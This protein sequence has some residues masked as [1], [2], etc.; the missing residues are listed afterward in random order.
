MVAVSIDDNENN[1]LLVEAFASSLGV[2]VRS[3]QDPQKALT[4]LEESPRAVDIVFVDYMMPGLNGL[5]VIRRYRAL[6]SNVPMVMITAAG[7]DAKLKLEA[8]EAGATDFL[9]KPLNAAEFK[10]RTANLLSLRK[11]QRLLE[12][13][14]EL[15]ES[16]VLKATRDIVEREHESLLVLG[17]TAEFKD[18]E[19]GSHIARVAHYSKLLARL[20]GLGEGQQD[21]IFYASPFHD[22]GKVGISDA[23][24]LKPG[25]LDEDEFEMMKTHAKIGYEIL[26]DTKSA[27][28]K[29]GA[30]IAISH[31]E[32]YDG[33]GYPH[34]LSGEQIPIYGRIVA[35][36][37]VFDALTSHRPYKE[38]WPFERAIALL[39]EESGKHF[40]PEL[41]RLFIDHI[42]E[43]REIFETFREE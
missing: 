3:F 25:R 30:I 41:V 32:K 10:A 28:L 42:S 17:K 4:L 20:S 26:K 21:T 40:D 33:S 24:L 16:E 9:N 2:K 18:P 13:R 14:A 43:V 27:Y 37:D 36:A 22:I 6:E 38:A 31:H 1:L 19:T 35:I 11:A 8:L 23:I 29:A 7:D 5:E 12:D 34:G 39:E 15:L